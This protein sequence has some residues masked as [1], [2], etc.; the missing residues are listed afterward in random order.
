MA[1]KPNTFQKLLHRFLMLRPVSA[2]LSVALHRVDM[3]MLKFTKGKHTVAELVGL[4]IIQVTTI[5]ARTGE[6]RTMP[7]V[8][9]IDGEKLALIGSNFGQKNNPGWYYNLKAHPQC[10]VKVNDRSR[11]YTA[12]ETQGEEME[13]YWQLAVSYY[14]GYE[15]YKLRA[16]H[17]Q[18]PVMV[19]EPAK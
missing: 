11:K 8:S 13:K 4:P 3:L 5:G 16:A 12:R 2:F 9:L 10:A 1:R 15:L 17:R 18:I 6:P 14:K 19:L 7:L